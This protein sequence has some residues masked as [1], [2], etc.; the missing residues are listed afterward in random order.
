MSH[1][2]Q[3]AVDDGFNNAKVA[4]PNGQTFIIP[5]RARV[6][7][8]DQVKLSSTAASTIG[9][10]NTSTDS[11]DDITY[12]VGAELEKA[13]STQFPGYPT[14]AL[15][16]VI[17]QHA[18]QTAGL[19]GQTVD[20]VT[21][22]PVRSFYRRGSESQKNNRLIDSK[23][24]NLS[25]VVTPK[26]G[27]AVSIGQQTVLPEGFAAWFDWIIDDSNGL[28]L[29]EERKSKY[30]AV[31]DIGGRTTDYAVIKDE[32]NLLDKSNSINAGMLDVRNAV[33]E[34]LM[35]DDRLAMD[36]EPS[37]QALDMALKT[38]TIRQFNKPVD[39]SAYVERAKSTV[40][41]KIKNATMERIGSGSELEHVILIGGGV[42]ALNGHLG[43]WFPHQT[44]AKDPV[45]ANA[46]GML[47]F[48]QYCAK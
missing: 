39:V 19:A 40:V 15:S 2:T 10:Y 12:V 16:R 43:D 8:N 24:A 47:K 1:A 35:N 6:G 30:V 22:L 5:S 33:L 4:L 44:V 32:N 31:I 46:R 45:F 7:S 27:E 21:S 38:G 25:K 48:A 17:V 41:E 37:E 14:S 26:H 13:E 23:I 18:L 11:G 9:E 29:N 20:L 36:E 42:E 3:V 28:S 34:A